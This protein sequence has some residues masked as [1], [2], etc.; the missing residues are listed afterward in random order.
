[1]RRLSSLPMRLG[2]RAAALSRSVPRASPR[3][4]TSPPPEESTAFLP[5]SPGSGRHRRSSSPAQAKLD[6]LLARVRP[7]EQAGVAPD[8]A[9]YTSALE[10]CAHAAA[11][12]RGAR[13]VL[14]AMEDAA[15]VPDVHSLALAAN[16]FADGGQRSLAVNA[17]SN[18]FHGG[19]HDSPSDHALST[20]GECD[21]PMQARTCTLILRAWRR[22]D[23]A[24]GALD[25]WERM[26]A[27]G[28]WP[29]TAGLQHLLVA[30]ASAGE[31]RNAREALLAAAEPPPSGGG[32]ATD[33]RNWNVVLS[34]CVHA[35]E[36]H[37]ARALLEELQRRAA[38]GDHTS[39]PDVTSF[40]T[41]LRAHVGEWAGGMGHAQR[42]AH[43]N[44]LLEAMAEAQV[45]RNEATYTS[46]FVL[47]RLDVP[48]V[49]RLLA[50]ARGSGVRL[51][52]NSY[53]HAARCLWWAGL[54]DRAWALMDEMRVEGVEPDG[55][56]Y[57]RSIV[58]A[59]SV[60]LLDEA[61]RLHRDAIRHGVAMRLPTATRPSDR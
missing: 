45:A 30:C 4:P 43:A 40:N 55:K 24:R 18:I 27:R 11:D 12:W 56:F 13:D 16:A 44:A 50:E 23:D 38:A 53:S 48:A 34:G 52:A 54:A 10:L 58:A 46:L 47:H 7:S 19:K 8:S 42:A 22:C 61:D 31:W 28:T 29:S 35:G 37:E 41:V 14:S 26:R 3:A 32:L 17:L 51:Q 9:D 15:L 21:T 39:A 33:A 60:G 1:M 49:E 6:E 20:T 36:V 57:A 5:G 25:A 2:E 59:E